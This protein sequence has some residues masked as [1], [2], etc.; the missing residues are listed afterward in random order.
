MTV[1][2]MFFFYC[3]LDLM[4]KRRDEV[5]ICENKTFLGNNCNCFFTFFSYFVKL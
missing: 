3:K 1:R 5:V 2:I 4:L